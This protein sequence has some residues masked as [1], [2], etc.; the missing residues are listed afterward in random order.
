MRLVM[1]FLEMRLCVASVWAMGQFMQFLLIT[2]V[3]E[4]VKK[5]GSLI[6][7]FKKSDYLIRLPCLVWANIANIASTH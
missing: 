5:L 1:Y 7:Q 2:I 4:N 3:T 6:R